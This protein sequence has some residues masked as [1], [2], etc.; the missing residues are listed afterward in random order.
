MLRLASE[1]VARGTAVARDAAA[2]LTRRKF[3]V[4]AEFGAG[5]EARP[6]IGFLR[7]T[8]RE[9]RNQNQAEQ[10]AHD[11]PTYHQFDGEGGVGVNGVGPTRGGVGKR[12]LQFA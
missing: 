9:Q 3:A 8:A 1:A 5:R 2:E 7:R 6:V 4:V 10:A 12:A 11:A